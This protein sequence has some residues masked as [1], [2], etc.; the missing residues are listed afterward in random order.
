MPLVISMVIGI[1]AISHVTFITTINF[2]I[3]IKKYK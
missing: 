2:I 1:Y 3:T